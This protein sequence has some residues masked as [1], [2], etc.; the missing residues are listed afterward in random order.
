LTACEI[1]DEPYKRADRITIGIT[2]QEAIAA[3]GAP[4][5]A[6]KAT[7]PCKSR[8]A[9]RELVYPAVTVYFGGLMETADG[10]V[11]LCIDDQGRVID[12]LQIDW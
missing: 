12:K 9:V 7:A 3:A 8:G 5:N 1:R 4:S 10:A 11:L 6:A 2:E